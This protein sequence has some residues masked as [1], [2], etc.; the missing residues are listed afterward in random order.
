MI[1]GSIVVALVAIA[2]PLT[3]HACAAG[4][5]PVNHLVGI[6]IASV[7]SSP[8]AWRAG[9]KAAI[10]ATWVGAVV[11]IVFAAISFSPTLSESAQSAFVVAAAILLLTALVVGSVFANRAALTALAKH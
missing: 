5:I 9:H 6:R 10:P 3:I 4:R 8:E 2:A 7:M 11:T 1:F